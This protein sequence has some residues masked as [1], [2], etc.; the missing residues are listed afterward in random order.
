[1]ADQ[2]DIEQYEIEGVKYASKLIHW[3]ERASVRVKP[4]RLLEDEEAVGKIYF[5]PELVPAV[6]HPLILE[7]GKPVIQ[8]VLV[9]RLHLYLDFTAELEQGA[10]TPV[11]QRISRGRIGFELPTG[12]LED[13]YRIC[14]DEAYHAQFSD[15]LM[16]QVQTVTGIVPNL[17]GLPRFFQ[18]LIQIRGSLPWDLQEMA[19][20]FFT[21]VSETL[22]S[23]ILSDIPNDV[24]V[25]SAVRDLV[26]DHAEDEGRHHAYFAK[27]LEYVWP[28]MNA[29]QKAAIG[30]LLPDFIKA[31]LEPDYPAIACE[32]AGCGLTS[33][34]VQQVL[35]ESYSAEEVAAGIRKAAGKTLQHFARVGILSEPGTLD[36]FYLSGLIR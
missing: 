27:L 31:F 25:V 15:D 22:I 11:T 9:Q 7:R 14:T 19:T 20:L 10:V 4:R 24:R 29:Y 5:P 2:R 13:A 33:E 17:P 28:Q 21:I 30:P 35:H 36:S 12:M 3:N 26:Q 6:Q 34:E 32:L 18:R 1:M 23:A 16:R 8:Q